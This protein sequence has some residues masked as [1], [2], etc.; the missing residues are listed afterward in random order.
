MKCCS[1]NVIYRLT[2]VIVLVFLKPSSHELRVEIGGHVTEGTFKSSDEQGVLKLGNLSQDYISDPDLRT[3]LA[4]AEL[5]AKR[6]KDFEDQELLLATS[7]IYSDKF[8]LRGKR[9]RQVLILSNICCVSN[10]KNCISKVALLVCIF[11]VPIPPLNTLFVSSFLA[12]CK[13]QTAVW[14][15]FVQ[16]M[17]H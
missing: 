14:I 10:S 4:N 1:Q 5:D 11:W 16:V 8:V 12:R 7:V 3:V 9:K 13:N 6:M 17:F 15:V 2:H